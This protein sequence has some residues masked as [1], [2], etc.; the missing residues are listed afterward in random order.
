MTTTNTT[1][2]INTN[3]LLLSYLSVVSNT[4][5]VNNCLTSITI[6]ANTSCLINQYIVYYCAPTLTSTDNYV[7]ANYGCTL[8]NMISDLRIMDCN[9]DPT[10]TYSIANGAIPYSYNQFSLY[11]NSNLY[12][13]YR[14]I[15]NSFIYE[16]TTATTQTIYLFAGLQNQDNIRIQYG[17]LKYNIIKSAVST[18]SLTTNVLSSTYRSLTVPASQLYQITTSLG[19]VAIPTANTQLIC[20]EVIIKRTATGTNKSL[21]YFC[22]RNSALTTFTPTSLYGT[23]G[24]S[25]TITFDAT[26]QIIPESYNVINDVCGGDIYNGMETYY[27]FTSNFIYYNNNASTQTLYLYVG[28]FNNTDTTFLTCTGVLSNYVIKTTTPTFVYTDNNTTPAYSATTA[29]AFPTIFSTINNNI[30]SDKSITIPA[31]K[32]YL[33]NL[34]INNRSNV[35]YS[36]CTLI[37][38]LNTSLAANIVT[39]SNPILNIPFSNSAAIINLNPSGNI[40]EY[41]LNYNTY[42]LVDLG[43]TNSVSFV[44]DNTTNVS[45]ITLYIFMYYYSASASPITNFIFSLFGL[46][47]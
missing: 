47:I 18:P 43:D 46:E 20:Q 13:K 11:F 3:Y 9:M 4:L 45:S 36:G 37:T 28:Y 31:S 34:Y 33:I 32:K 5:Y 29:R 30:G 39:T 8:T 40:I 26:A 41:S 6:P 35:D 12:G 14:N 7:L 1:T 19:S 42:K 38:L 27:T 23:T 17:T 21:F 16:N 10:W 2:T 15:S 22:S 24:A 25:T 44:Y